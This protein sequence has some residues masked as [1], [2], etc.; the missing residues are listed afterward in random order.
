[1]NHAALKPAAREIVIEEVFPHSPEAIWR[2]LTDRDLI[3]R[4]MPMQPVGF[5]PVE[6][7]CF[8]YRTAPAGA[9]DG[10]IDCEV[11]EVTPNQRLAFTW[12]GGDEANVGYGSRLETVVT[13]TLSKVAG[14]T[15]IQLVHSGFVMPRN[16]TAFTGMSKGW[17]KVIENIGGAASGHALVQ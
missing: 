1:M 13:F 15:L 3:G 17:P 11:I 7:T 8:T 16:E 10:T 9:W 4:W 2:A 12:K 6:G 14:G 5:E